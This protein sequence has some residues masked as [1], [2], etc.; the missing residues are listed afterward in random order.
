MGSDCWQP[1][2]RTHRLRHP[3]LRARTCGWPLGLW[4]GVVDEARALGMDRVLVVC[5][6]GNGASAKT[7][8][9]QGGV[10]ED[11]PRTAQRAPRGATGSESASRKSNSLN[12]LPGR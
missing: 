3:A 5:E 10:L 12:S 1:M 6:A 8:E 9:R 11:G 2:S 4:V 7:I